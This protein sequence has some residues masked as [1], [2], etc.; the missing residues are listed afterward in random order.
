M[1]FFQITIPEGAYETKRLKNEIKRPIID[2]RHYSEN[3]YQITIKPNFSTLG[4][5]SE[6]LPQGPKISFVFDDSK[7]SLLG[8]HGTILYIEYYLSPNLVDFLSFDNIFLETNNAQGMI[9]KGK[10]SGIIHKRT[11]T[12]DPGYTF[13]EKFAG[14]ISWYMMVSKTLFQQIV[15]N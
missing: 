11:M 7:R 1:I 15:L 12:L 5:S 8:F 3:G 10:R 14:G 4:S 2:Q 6:I 13:V 9:F